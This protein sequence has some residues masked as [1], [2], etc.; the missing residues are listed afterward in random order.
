MITK[1][2]KKLIDKL[3]IPNNVKFNKINSNSWFNI[4]KCNYENEILLKNT[5]NTKNININKT[6]TRNKSI[7]IFFNNKHKKILRRW[8]KIYKYTYNQTI[9]Y[10]NKSK[11]SL[12]DFRKL[13]PIIKKN[14][15]KE[16]TKY[17]KYSKIP[18][19]TI[20]EAIR[21]VVTSYKSAFTNL[22]ESNIKYF[23]IRYKKDKSARM[24][25]K[26]EG[27]SF[28]NG[29]LPSDKN[30]YCLDSLFDSSYK[31][32]YNNNNSFCTSVFGKNLNTSSSIKGIERTSII[33]WNKRTNRYF[34]NT[35][36]DKSLENLNK[37]NKLDIC[38]IDPGIRTFMTVYGTK[39]IYQI[40]SN[41]KEMLEK[42]FNKINLLKEKIKLN[43]PVIEQNK[44]KKRINIIQQK[45]E[46]RVDDMHFKVSKFL[47]KN[48]RTIL[49][50]KLS[51]KSICSNKNTLNKITK[52]HCYS[53]KHYSFRNK[54]QNCSELNNN[55]VEFVSEH[56]TSKTCCKCRRRNS[57]YSNEIFNCSFCGYKMNRD[58]MGAYNI[59]YK[60]FDK[61]KKYLK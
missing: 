44:M 20:D 51:T 43:K 36:V 33:T 9:R 22:R 37:E 19:H 42:E 39:D 12:I 53:L 4:T 40:G 60:H 23:R 18:S 11:L 59:F 8:F 17:I 58:I 29:N 38:A 5:K 3:T 6:F 32:K 45:I 1:K 47:C 26:I 52:K 41:S 35:P 50:G 28:P 10:I 48:F 2:K 21:D 31:F 34:L 61:V 54:L 49:L 30:N 56:Y 16:M 46:N 7:E 25:L 15:N 13:R 24:S 27:T 55:K 14:F 57:S